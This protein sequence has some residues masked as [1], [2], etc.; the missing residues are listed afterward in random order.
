[1]RPKPW[2]LAALAVSL[3]PGVVSARTSISK[4]VP[5]TL[6]DQ[7]PRPGRD[8]Q[9]PGPFA[10]AAAARAIAIQSF[11]LRSV[12]VDAS[13]L[14]PG[15]LAAAWRPFVGHLLDTNS[16]PRITEALEAVYARADIAMY[17]VTVETQDVANGVLR[18]RM[19]EGSV[20]RAE[21]S[22]V[23]GARNRALVQRYVDKIV[24]E[25]PLRQS[26]LQRYVSA[27]RDIPGLDSQVRLE[28]GDADGGMRMK[29]ALRPHPVQLGLAINNQGVAYLGRTQVQADLYFNSVLRQGDQTRLTVA[30]PWETRLLQSYSV[31]QVEPIGANGLVATL[32]ANYLRT[33]PKDTDLL[34]HATTVGVQLSYPL[35]RSYDQSL[36]VSLGADGVNNQNAFL[37]FTFADDRTRALRATVAYDRQAGRLLLAARGALSLG[38]DGLGA[39]ATE[40][41]SGN[42]DFRKLNGKVGASFGLGERA[43]LR[44]NAAGQWTS[45]HLPATE[46]FALGGAAF[47]RGYAASVIAGDYGIAGS[48]ELAYLPARMPAVLRGSESFAFIDGG[49][50]GFKT[51]SGW[52]PNHATLASAGIGVRAKVADR[53]VVQLEAAK[54]IDNRLPFLGRRSWRGVATIRALF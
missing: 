34:G 15:E 6:A 24:A 17:A 39:R 50:I 46:Q 3:C 53:A 32:S 8:I 30:A 2:L 28:T 29:L 35:L 20:E 38:I 33:R 19:L 40:R 12:V 4:V 21:I 37:G 48:A 22:A 9:R 13:S 10:P 42:P 1:M 26:T 51:R 5:Q 27:T 14:A 43:T 31:E 7:N 11:V 49:S 47:G 45:E 18:I 36:V 25:R 44:L 54:P 23:A 41:G 16:L 52:A